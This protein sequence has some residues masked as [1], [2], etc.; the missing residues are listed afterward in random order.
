MIG[1]RQPRIEPEVIRN[2][3][4]KILA[5]QSFQGAGR[6][7]GLLRFLVERTLNGC[8]DQLKEYTLGAE[9]LGRG[10]KFD[11][12]VDSIARVEA[13]R[14]RQR[15]ETYYA[16][17]GQS[18]PIRIRLPKGA[19]VP[20]FEGR[21]P[22]SPA[23]AL[24]WKALAI[25]A[26]AFAILAL[27]APWRR[28]ASLRQPVTRVEID[29]GAGVSLRSSQVGSSSV[30]V[31]RDGRRLVFVSFG[32]DG[33][34]RLMTKRLDSVAGS[35][36]TQLPGT[37]GARGP[38]FS[39]DG[40]WVA[41][42]AR[43]KLWKTSVEGGA[44]VPLCDAQELLGGAWGDNDTIV[45]ALSTTGLVRLSAE[46]GVPARIEGLENEAGARW[47][48]LLP[49]ARSVLFTA[50]GL[51]Q[52]PERVVVFSMAD[53]RTKI[54][55]PKGSYGRYLNSGHLAYADEGTLFVAPFDLDR[56]ELT[57]KPVSVMSDVTMNLAGSAEFDVSATGMLVCRR[58]PGGARSVIQ[59]L[60]QSG[61]TSPLLADPAEYGS[62]R[63]SPNG[64]RLAFF[65][66]SGGQR[67][68][69]DLRVFD[70]SAGKTLAISSGRLY[71]SPVWTPDGRFLLAATS[72]G[73]GWIGADGGGSV[74]K[75]LASDDAQVPWSFDA[76]GQRLAFYQRG[77]SRNSS[78]TFDL[79]TAP[80]RITETSIT[81][82]TP[83]P[84]VV[85]GAFEVY[86]AFSPDGR[87]I[88][89]SSLESGAYEVYVRAFP[90]TG[91]TWQVSNGGGLV[92]VWSRDGRRL[93]Y[94][95]TDQRIM[96][97][98]C[99]ANGAVFQARSPRVWAP[100]QIADTGVLPNF[101]V[102][103]DGRVAALMPVGQSGEPQSP[104][105]VT[106]VL[107]FAEELRRSAR[108]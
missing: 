70:W 76:R 29:L 95:T 99:T 49:G 54:V 75:L 85:S 50:G 71:S 74:G 77:L 106:L 46:G 33:A 93:F 97:V 68:L 40:R 34:P 47:P 63:F 28:S 3:L 41:Y 14:L 80:I 38:F 82:G 62:P 107:N 94:R 19:Y 102:S 108:D 12:R 30:I 43:G 101:D 18:D 56:M 104:S 86:P 26:S 57:G 31:S 5:S 42:F 17:E 25:A 72:G 105:H 52:G 92:A 16:T 4:E 9:A 91:R 78:V 89:Y 51:G 7:G 23:R 73:I 67:D 48:Q 87:W 98:D 100:T 88:A 45:A 90:D 61:K 24:P 22:M 66:N 35:K 32:N 13:S 15:L 39:W 64:T 81:A 53:R 84:Y 27:W 36:S 21:D 58:R 60:H 79:W 83:E 44:P 103:P 11:P 20:A 1:M 55:A 96:V 37:E 10:E 65:L 6:S 2:H 59:W 8:A 69:Q